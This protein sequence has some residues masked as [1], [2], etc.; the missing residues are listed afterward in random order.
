MKIGP[1]EVKGNVFL[2]PM[3]GITDPPFRRVVQQFGASAVWTE[4]ISAQGLLM[5]PDAF[6]TMDLDG[7]VVPTVFQI[8]GTNPDVMGEA[9]RIVVDQGA[10]AL[11]INMGCPARQVVHKGAG[12]ALMQDI[13]LAS[14]IVRAVRRAAPIALTVKIRSGWSAGNQNAPEFARAME[15]EGADAVIVHCRSRD[16]RHSGP[17]SME[18]LAEV[19]NAVRIR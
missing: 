1:L 14:R 17:V 11:D 15:A 6:G 4:M 13:P 19:K 9:A 2:A 5:N 10:S 7:H 3:A 8:Y 16:N 12:A 18:I